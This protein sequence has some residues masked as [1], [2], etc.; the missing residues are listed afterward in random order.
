M[1]WKL[2]ISN[3]RWFEHDSRSFPDSLDHCPMPINANQNHAIDMKYLSMP[4]IANQYGIG[5]KIKKLWRKV[6]LFYD[7]FITAFLSGLLTDWLIGIDRH[8]AMIEGVLSF[9]LGRNLFLHD[10]L[11]WFWEWLDYKLWSSGVLLSVVFKN[12]S[13]GIVRI[14]S[15]IKLHGPLPSLYHNHCM[16]IKNNKIVKK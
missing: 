4:I 12:I 8:W 16:V 7:V 15:C 6:H 13:Y 3:D 5:P 10:Q 2:D 11:R 14:I 1:F 9:I